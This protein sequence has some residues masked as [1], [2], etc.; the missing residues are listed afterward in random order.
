MNAKTLARQYDQ[1]TGEERFQLSIAAGARGD[2]VRKR[3]VW[4]FVRKILAAGKESQERTA[5]L[6]D[7]IA[8]RAFETWITGFKRVEHRAL[9]GLRLDFERHL[10]LDARQ[11]PQMRRK[12]DADHDNVWTSTESTAGR[13]RTMGAQLSPASFDAYTC[14]P[15]VPK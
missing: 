1:L 3:R 10:A 2:R 14:P 13:S 8:D 15:V 11:R 12:H 9:R 5:L 6:R 4:L 7:V